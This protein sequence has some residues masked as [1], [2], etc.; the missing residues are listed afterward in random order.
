MFVPGKSPVKMQPEILDISIF[1]HFCIAGKLVCSLCETIAGSLSV[2]STAVSSPKVAVID[3]GEVGR[4]AVYS[5]HNKGP[6]F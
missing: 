1:N 5:R 2:A 6:Q 3:F 4:S